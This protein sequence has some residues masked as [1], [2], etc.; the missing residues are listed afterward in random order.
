M[1]DTLDTEKFRTYF[2]GAPL[3]KVPSRK[4]P[5]E[6]FYT[7]KSEQNY[8]EAAVRTSL[9]ID[10]CK[11]LGGILIFLTG[12][13]EIDQACDDIWNESSSTTTHD[14]PKLVVCPFYS[15]LTP[16]Q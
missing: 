14:L 7:T 12:Q 1:L 4:F 10:M 8:V 15:S 3:M 5:V 11:G 16:S 13:M 2:H 6:V 9:L